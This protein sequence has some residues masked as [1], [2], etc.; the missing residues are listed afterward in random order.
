MK[1]KKTSFKSTVCIYDLMYK[2]HKKGGEL[3]IVSRDGLGSYGGTTCGPR[4]T[5][6]GQR[7]L[8]VVSQC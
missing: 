6:T 7:G 5:V 8:T 3:G 1:E 4:L 2:I